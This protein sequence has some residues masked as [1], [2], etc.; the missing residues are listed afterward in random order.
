VHRFGELEAAIMAVMWSRDQPATV[1]DVYVELAGSR[2]LAYTTVMTVMDTLH[3]KGFLDR[4]MQGRA[5][6][7][8]P[9]ISR[10]KYTAGIMREA[11][12]ESGDRT[13]VLAHFVAAMSDQEAA[14]L[15]S[16]LRRR[17]GGNDR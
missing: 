11:M 10:Q 12:A 14:A 13:A 9:T 8:R 15:R 5:W 6:S 16:L 4:E 7:Y 2:Q 1:R 17:S 3:R